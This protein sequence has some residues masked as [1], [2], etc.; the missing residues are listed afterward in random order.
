[1]PNPLMPY[2][3]S[4]HTVA[5]YR[6]IQQQLGQDLVVFTAMNLVAQRRGFVFDLP[7]SPA[8]YHQKHDE[9]I[10][11]LS[12]YRSLPN[13]EGLFFDLIEE[14][15][16]QL[17]GQDV[18]AERL[19]D[20]IVL[21]TNKDFKVR[22]SENDAW[23]I[24]WEL[25]H[26]D[27]LQDKR[28]IITVAHKSDWGDVVPWTVIQ[29]LDSGF[30]LYKQKSYATAL[31]L[32]SIAVEATLRDVLSTK[33][34]GF[35]PHAS[36]VDVYEFS[37]AQVN[38]SGSD[39]TLTFLDVLPKGAGELLLSA[40]GILPIDIKIRRNKNPD[41]DDLLI[42]APQYLLDHWSGNKIVQ[43]AETKNIGG[44][45]EALKIAR[46]VERIITKADLFPDV[47]EVLQAIRNNLIHLSNNSLNE[48][49]PQLSAVLK[50]K[51]TLKDFIDQPKYV[52]D[53]LI[54][55]PRFI[56]DQYVKLWQSKIH[57]P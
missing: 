32:M 13:R 15:Q 2:I 25:E 41:K 51:I 18:H 44:L 35:N 7:E 23:L 31:A 3:S 57:L 40:G 30:L 11:S 49:L 24:E 8:E 10:L 20:L 28:K 46:V 48:E 26:P 55:I 14:I 43:P 5:A 21:E 36:K 29:Y 33:G 12:R 17:L 19:R 54:D 27:D 47:D 37:R 39:Y 4:V 50:K 56:N 9:I 52:F 1:M 16:C 22:L 53:Y 6:R 45:G 42:R 38:V 34:Y